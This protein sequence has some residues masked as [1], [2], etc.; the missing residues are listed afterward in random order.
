MS[1]YRN[2]PINVQVS[3]APEPST[4]ALAAA[5]LAGLGLRA[6]RRRRAR[7]EP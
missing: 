2:V 3:D 4:L 7:W 5:G 1:A 6:W